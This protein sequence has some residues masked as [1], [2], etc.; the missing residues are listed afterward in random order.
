MG[1]GGHCP[2]LRNPR[3]HPYVLT[4]LILPTGVQ[5]FK[6]VD[7]KGRYKNIQHIL[8]SCA[9]SVAQRRATELRDGYPAAKLPR[10]SLPR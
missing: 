9:T 3:Y 10:A 2:P 5:D 7:T 6:K 4:P 8:Q 1:G